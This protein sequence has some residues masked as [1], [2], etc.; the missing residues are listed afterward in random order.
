VHTEFWWGNLSERD[1]LEDLGV[2]G[3]TV[4]KWIFKDVGWRDMNLTDVGQDRD[5][6]R[7]I[8][9]AV[10]NVRVPKNSGNF[11]TS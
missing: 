6:W 5:R 10:M 7:A 2:N 9:N 4:L 3:K 11:L 8:V 1:Q